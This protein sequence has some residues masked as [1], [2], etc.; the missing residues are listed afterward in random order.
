[1]QHKLGETVATW[2]IGVSV[3]RVG[4]PRTKDWTE[5]RQLAKVQHVVDE[6]FTVT[7]KMIINIAGR[8]FSQRLFPW[9][10]EVTLT[11]SGVAWEMT[12]AGATNPNHDGNAHWEQVEWLKILRYPNGKAQ[13]LLRYT[14]RHGA[15]VVSLESKASKLR[16][17][18]Q[19]AYEWGGTKFSA[20]PE[21]F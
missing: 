4:H 8:E 21:P 14:D 17:F 18:V 2:R 19:R 20:E 16:P 10:N 7:G 13:L 12:T 3:R 6:S 5:D 1:M 9:V 15:T 11:K